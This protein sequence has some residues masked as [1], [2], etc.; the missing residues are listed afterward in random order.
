MFL[1]LFF[2]SE[3]EEENKTLAEL[4][5]STENTVIHQ[6]YFNYVMFK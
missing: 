1:F 6:K 3:L 4:E 2:C 5:V